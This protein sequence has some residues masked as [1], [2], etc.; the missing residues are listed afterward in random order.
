MYKQAKITKYF[1]SCSGGRT[2]D[3][4]GDDD[5]NNNNKRRM[6]QS[7]H[8]RR[9]Q[10]AIEQNDLEMTSALVQ[11]RQDGES[12]LCAGMT[13]LQIAALYGHYGIV[14]LLLDVWLVDV[15]TRGSDGQT[16][17]FKAIQNGHTLITEYLCSKGA[18]VNAVDDYGNTPLHVVTTHGRA[19]VTDL[20]GFNPLGGPHT[21][22]LN[23][24]N[25]N[26]Q[27]ALHLAVEHKADA[28]T[29]GRRAV[30]QWLIYWGADCNVGDLQGRTPLHLAILADNWIVVQYMLLRKRIHPFRAILLAVAHGTPQRVRSL[31]ET[32]TATLIT[33]LNCITKA[34]KQPNKLC[35]VD[36]LLTMARPVA[37]FEIDWVLHTAISMYSLAG[38]VTVLCK[39]VTNANYTSMHGRMLLHDLAI[40]LDGFRV[41]A[42]LLLDRGAD[43][44]FKDAHGRT[45]LHFAVCSRRDSYLAWLCLADADINI[46]D[47][48]MRTPLHDAVAIGSTFG[49]AVLR[50]YGANLDAVDELGRTPL[51]ILLDDRANR[52][53]TAV[54]VEFC[55]PPCQQRPPWHS[56]TPLLY[57][58]PVEIMCDIF[59]RLQPL[60][61]GHPCINVTDLVNASRVCVAWYVIARGMLGDAMMCP[62]PPNRSTYADRV[63]GFRALLES[64]SRWTELRMDYNTAVTTVFVFVDTLHANPRCCAALLQIM[65]ITRPKHVGLYLDNCTTVEIASQMPFWTQLA[66]CAGSVSKLMIRFPSRKYAD[67]LVGMYIRAVKDTLSTVTLIGDVGPHTCSALAECSKVDT[68]TL[69]GCR[70]SIANSPINNTLAA[71]LMLRHVHLGI[72][73]GDLSNTIQ[74]LLGSSLEDVIVVCNSTISDM[75]AETLLR[76]LDQLRQRNP[77]LQYISVKHPDNM[78]RLVEIS[79]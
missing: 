61:R 33:L 13:P 21:S 16:A 32:V 57:A 9:L 23:R 37:A 4:D 54:M 27:T 69:F 65:D 12:C 35:I 3:D 8:A 28:N 17:L 79:I 74:C 59:T 45:P 68:T 71:L 72:V 51:H 42:L 78:H 24:Q 2:H 55:N 64:A 36:T 18:N 62:F 25:I 60:P 66:G 73:D 22:A 58:L 48:R 14:Q 19:A 67:N 34:A 50:A 75:A 1:V 38:I 20:T 15:D 76:E 63:I 29:D 41:I 43:I 77:H 40:Y 7:P 6:L 52:G 11:N 46:S 26:Q 53:Q 70:M 39:H 31:F 56:T 47:N 10:E 49:F 44:N 5:N 30:A